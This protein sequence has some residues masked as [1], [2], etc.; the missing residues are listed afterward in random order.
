MYR[1]EL[2]PPFIRPELVPQ[3]LWGRNLRVLLSRE[4]W[5]AV[6]RHTYAEA[7]Y[8]CRVCGG[9]GPQWPVEAD[10]TWEYD[11]Y[12]LRHT[13]KGVVALCPDCHS[14]RHWGKTMVDGREGEAYDKMIAVNSCAREIAENIVKLAFEQWER[15]SGLV[16]S[17]DYSWI[18]QTHGIKLDP[19][20]THRAES[21][22]RE[23]VSKAIEAT[24]DDVA[25]PDLKEEC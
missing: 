1:P 20:A 25:E 19:D 15:R 16:W 23:L 13:L 2:A 22:N 10:E 5:D 4:E 14:V 7:G 17:S 11:E 21:V 12:A 18:E 24:Q 6:R 8:R 3:P 9:R